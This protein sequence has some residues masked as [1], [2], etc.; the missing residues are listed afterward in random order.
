MLVL[1]CNCQQ[2]NLTC[3]S[4]CL[5]SLFVG[6]TE[7][8]TEQVLCVVNYSC[9]VPWFWHLV[10]RMPVDSLAEVQFSNLLLQ[11]IFHTFQS[12]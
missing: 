9:P 6:V 5:G 1:V 7:S 8:V 10:F 4:W 11:Y 2:V 12:Q 3:S